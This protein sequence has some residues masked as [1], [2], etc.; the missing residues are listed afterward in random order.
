MANYFYDLPE[1]LIKHI[2]SFNEET[3]KQ[4]RQATMNLLLNWF[5]DEERN[6]SEC[7]EEDETDP[8]DI[9]TDKL[10]EQRATV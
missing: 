4:A 5:K 2:H 10:Q 1:D 8:S 7:M 6:Y 3:E 9:P